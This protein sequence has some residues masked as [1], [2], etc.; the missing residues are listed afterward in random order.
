GKEGKGWWFKTRKKGKDCEEDAEDK[1]G[2]EGKKPERI[3]PAWAFVYGDGSIWA[4]AEYLYA[5]MKDARM[6]AL[7]TQGSLADP[8]PGALGQMGTQVLFGGDIETKEREG[9]RFALGFWLGEGHNLGLDGSVFFLTKQSVNFATAG[10]P[11]A[12]LGIPFFDAS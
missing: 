5:W 2:G 10:F 9:G 6:P 8:R 12:V 3:P 1:E 4:S 7:A 11:S